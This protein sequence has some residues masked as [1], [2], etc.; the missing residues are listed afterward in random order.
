MRAHARGV[1]IGGWAVATA[2]ALAVMAGLG[3]GRFSYTILLPSTREGLGLSY[4]SAGGLGAAN[5]IGYLAG[6]VASGA[7]SRRIGAR[8]TAASA[9][10]ALSVSLAWM[11]VADGP[12][13]AAAARVLAGIAGGVV[14]VQALGLVAAWFSGPTRGLASGVMHCGNG[15]GLILTGLGLPFVLSAAS[16]SAGWRLGWMVLALST[17]LV[18]PL[19]WRYLRAPATLDAADGPAA[20]PRPV[21]QTSRAPLGVCAGLYGLFGFSYIVYVTFFAEMLRSRGLS[22]EQIGVVWAMIGAFS[23]AS[24]PVWGSVSDRIGRLPGVG[25]VFALQAIAY[26]VFLDGSVAGLVVSATLFGVTAWGIPAIMAAAMG[27]GGRVDDAVSGF[28]RITTA[29]AVGQTLGPLVAGRLADLTGVV[30]SGL[31]LSI[32]AAIAAG[33]WSFSAGKLRGGVP[34]P[35]AQPS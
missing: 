8:A 30:T 19:G 29:M 13:E 1:A 25:V 24:G 15:V 10:A 5:L 35:G 7:V 4:T 21:R 18:V 11:A 33:V 23:L 2:G 26:L 9:L 3:F 17:A 14:Y 22:L 31:W 6:S 20:G 27:D 34:V 12:S 28:G 16:P 32:L